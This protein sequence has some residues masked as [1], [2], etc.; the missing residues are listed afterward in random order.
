MATPTSPNINQKKLYSRIKKQIPEPKQHKWT[1]IGAKALAGDEGALARLTKRGL[2]G[3]KGAKSPKGAKPPK[4][5]KAPSGSP[6]PGTT[7]TTYRPPAITDEALA[8]KSPQQVSPGKYHDAITGLDVNVNYGANPYH[9][10]G[11]A[12]TPTPPKGPKDPDIALQPPG[13]KNTIRRLGRQ[14]QQARKAGDKDK[15]RR[16]H[17]HLRRI[18]S[19]GYG[20]ALAK[21]TV[22]GLAKQRRN[23]RERGNT[24]QARALSAQIKKLKRRNRALR[25]P[26]Q[27]GVE[28]ADRIEP[29]YRPPKKKKDKKK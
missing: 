27:T 23:A 6:S 16:L 11:A 1:Q 28:A 18:R 25:S 3:K 2:I 22:G 26:V 5:P 7:L 24:D 17:R 15:A 8:A 14:L 19:L 21:P 20:E 13:R 4:A 9:P 29:G 12:S 10:T